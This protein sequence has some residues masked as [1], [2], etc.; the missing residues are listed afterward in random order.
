MG[1]LYRT[2]LPSHKIFPIGPDKFLH[3]SNDG[4]L[5]IYENG[6]IVIQKKYGCLNGNI[7]IP[8][9]YGRSNQYNLSPIFVYNPR[10]GEVTTYFLS[11]NLGS[12]AKGK[13]FTDVRLHFEE[14]HCHIMNNPWRNGHLLYSR[15]WA[16]TKIFGISEYGLEPIPFK[17]VIGSVSLPTN[18]NS[19][20]IS[21]VKEGYSYCLILYSWNQILYYAL[22]DENH[23][24]FYRMD[25]VSNIPS[26][27][28]NA[29]VDVNTNY[30]VVLYHSPKNHFSGRN[31][32][33]GQIYKVGFFSDI[34]VLGSPKISLHNTCAVTCP[35]T[36][37]VIVFN[38]DDNSFSY[39]D[40]E[41]KDLV[42]LYGVDKLYNVYKQ[43][44]KYKGLLS[45]AR[46]EINLKLD[47]TPQALTYASKILK[48]PNINDTKLCLTMK[49]GE[50]IAQF[51]DGEGRIS[52]QEIIP[53]NLWKDAFVKRQKVKDIVSCSPVLNLLRMSKTKELIK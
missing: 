50:I 26:T 49:N 25:P 23:N 11:S 45:P 13:S 15:P 12:I 47:L 33:F 37:K 5:T 8:M 51:C 17:R 30:I 31:K 7:C 16:Y 20:W 18:I 10:F 6:K 41:K 38:G 40:H 24:Y 46:E 42:P 39:Y 34:C 3:T 43:L 35:Y 27:S 28:I 48:V 36:G 21:I 53:I 4:N 29:A 9:H 32:E 52:H 14:G 19:D 22:M 44:Q 1:S 2:D